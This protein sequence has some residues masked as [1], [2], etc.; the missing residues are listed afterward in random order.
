MSTLPRN[1]FE[2]RSRT[3][4]TRRKPL[5]IGGIVLLFVLVW[6]YAVLSYGGEAGGE[7]GGGPSGG[8][9][10]GTTAAG[11]EQAGSGSA[12]GATTGGTT[13][14]F[15][16]EPSAVPDEAAY[17]ESGSAGGDTSTEI[18]TGTTTG[19]ATGDATGGAGNGLEQSPSPSSNGDN[20][21]DDTGQESPDT[22][23][24]HDHA[25]GAANEPGSY[26]P[27]GTG[28]S[29]GDLAPVDEERLRYAASSF[30]S[31]AYGYSGN[32]V[33]E[34]NQNVAQTVVWP[35]FYQSQGSS[36]VERYA[37]QVGE[38]GTKSAALMGEFETL[39]T[40]PDRITGYAYFETGSGYSEDG[41]L[42]GEIQAYRQEMTLVRSGA[43][44]KVRSVEKIE[45]TN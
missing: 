29:A 40:D 1:G 4:S 21:N 18:P 45:E 43:T 25:E 17:A 13:A 2:D 39:E 9:G 28:A 24:S 12:S 6:S 34:Y 5:I 44:W 22:P 7:A 26:D 42:E 35:Q 31:T 38:G 32:D 3:P 27:L 10:G 19:P 16:D 33:D 30:I 23:H 8:A 20:G 14:A 36:E 15:G 41:T 11:S 37:T